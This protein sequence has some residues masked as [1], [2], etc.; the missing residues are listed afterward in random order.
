VFVEIIRSLPVSEVEWGSIARTLN[1][2]EMSSKA[3]GKGMQD[4]QV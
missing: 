3:M 4:E 1:V 2:E